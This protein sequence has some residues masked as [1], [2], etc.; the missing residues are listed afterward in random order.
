MISAEG[1]HN[2]NDHVSISAEGILMMVA[3]TMTITGSNNAY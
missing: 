2:I 1:P 3:G